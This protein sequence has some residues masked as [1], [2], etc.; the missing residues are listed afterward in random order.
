[1]QLTVSRVRRPSPGRM[2]QASIWMT[3][4]IE[5]TPQ[6]DLGS[7]GRSA[8]NRHFHLALPLPGRRRQLPDQTPAFTWLSAIVT[9][10]ASGTS[11][12]A[13]HAFPPTPR[14]GSFTS[15]RARPR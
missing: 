15:P 3:S 1:M 10:S 14:G 11:S 6:G 13:A 2:F 4:V 8:Q 9:G 5:E 7:S 12:Q